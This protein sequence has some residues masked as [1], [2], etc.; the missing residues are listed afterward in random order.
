MA[1]W[2]GYTGQA[3]VQACQTQLVAYDTVMAS[4]S[5]QR[6]AHFM[7]ER[8]V[9][10]TVR[11]R[12]SVQVP[13]PNSM[14]TSHMYKMAISKTIN[15]YAQIPGTSL[16]IPAENIISNLTTFHV[17]LPLSIGVMFKRFGQLESIL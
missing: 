15:C 11:V 7:K 1:W 6:C 3:V 14:G 12:A 2:T 17:L 13:I 4:S 9:S 10:V 16:D 8:Q 5:Y